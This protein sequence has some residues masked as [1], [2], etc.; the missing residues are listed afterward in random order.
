VLDERLGE[1]L[2]L[3]RLVVDDKHAAA[4]DGPAFDSTWTGVHED[5]FI[6][7]GGAVE[8]SNSTRS[9]MPRRVWVGT[10]G[11]GSY[12]CSRRAAPR[13]ALL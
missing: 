13:T 2:S 7:T 1:L 11:I 3:E 9:E 6:R 4:A 8:R 12:A 10:R 5:L